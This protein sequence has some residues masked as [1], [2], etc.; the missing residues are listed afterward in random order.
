MKNEWAKGGEDRLLKHIDDNVDFAIEN[1]QERRDWT[2]E[3]HQD[4]RDLAHKYYALSTYVS[5]YA[6]TPAG[7]KG[8]MLGSI[9]LISSGKDWQHLEFANFPDPTQL[10]GLDWRDG[11]PA[12]L[13]SLIPVE[14]EFGVF[15]RRPVAPIPPYEVEGMTLAQVDGEAQEPGN[16]AIRKGTSKRV[17]VETLVHLL[18]AIAEPGNTPDYNLRGKILYTWGDPTSLRLYRRLGFTAAPELL[19][20]K[21]DQQKERENPGSQRRWALL[22]LRPEDFPKVIQALENRPDFSD[23]EI[24]SLREAMAGFTLREVTP[25]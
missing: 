23:E 20:R 8:Q 19:V 18:R 13:L 21:A 15:V 25:R 3:I 6:K 14:D 11:F 5:V 22:S 12:N 24:E 17:F 9:R 1:Y 16:W 2:P 10:S 4:L 7:G